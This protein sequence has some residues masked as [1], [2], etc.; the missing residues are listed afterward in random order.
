VPDFYPESNLQDVPKIPLYLKRHIS[1]K[2]L[3]RKKVL[4]NVLYKAHLLDNQMAEN[5]FPILLVKRET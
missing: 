4:K 3:S 2:F 1:H 5:N